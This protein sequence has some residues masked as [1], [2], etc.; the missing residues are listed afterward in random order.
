M[1]KLNA[2]PII[3]PITIYK[4]AILAPITGDSD[5]AKLRALLDHFLDNNLEPV[6]MRTVSAYDSKVKFTLRLPRETLE[7]LTSYCQRTLY[8]RQQ[9]FQIAICSSLAALGV[10]HYI[11]ESERSPG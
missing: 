3:T 10:S 4:T 8:T 6:D 7:K 5:A 2:V 11:T 9:A 1:A